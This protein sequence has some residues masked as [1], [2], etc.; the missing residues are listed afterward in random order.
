MKVFFSYSSGPISWF[1]IH[2][3]NKKSLMLS[4]ANN[5]IYKPIYSMVEIGSNKMLTHNLSLR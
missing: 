4:L 2:V 5:L 3:S 1:N